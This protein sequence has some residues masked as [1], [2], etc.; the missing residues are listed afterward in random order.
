ML[1]CADAAVASA[2]LAGGQ[3]A[4]PS[5]GTG[6]LARW[7]HGRERVIRLLGSATAWLRPDRARC[8]SCRRTHILL[9]SWCA[10]RRA[11]AIEVIGTGLAAAL[12]GAGCTRIGADLDVPPATVRDWLRRLRSRAEAMRC[13]A[14]FQLG[15]I[16]GIDPA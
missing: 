9:P 4:Y 6:R 13:F 7:G 12:D 3:L 5:C 8:R 11:D 10:P 1:L 14:M 16:G 2:D 15:A